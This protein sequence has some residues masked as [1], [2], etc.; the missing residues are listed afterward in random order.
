MLHRPCPQLVDSAVL[1]GQH[2]RIWSVDRTTGLK[3]GP[4]RFGTNG[5]LRIGWSVLGFRSTAR[6]VPDRALK[7]SQR[8]D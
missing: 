8:L 1:G 4:R 7:R 5:S 6:R 2:W 3:Y